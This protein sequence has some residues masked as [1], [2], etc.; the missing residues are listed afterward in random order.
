M[1]GGLPAITGKQLVRIL[2]KD[3]W[4]KKSLSKHGESYVKYDKTINKL[5]VTTVQFNKRNEPIPNITL[6]LIL[7]P[8]QTNIG[9]NGLLKL[10]EEY[11]IK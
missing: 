7:G 4:K 11:G 8:D 6:H 3:G 10:I 1:S 9:R 5:R 2:K